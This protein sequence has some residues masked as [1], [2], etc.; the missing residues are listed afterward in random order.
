MVHEL[1]NGPQGSPSPHRVS[2][3]RTTVAG[4]A[5]GRRS[6]CISQPSWPVGWWPRLLPV[7]HSRRAAGV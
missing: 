5:W 2:K 3:R 7:R 4:R 1:G 6:R